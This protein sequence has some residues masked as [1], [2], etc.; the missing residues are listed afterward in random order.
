MGNRKSNTKIKSVT[1]TIPLHI[2]ETLQGL[3]DGCI[4]SA[5]DMAFVEEMNIVLDKLD[6]SINKVRYS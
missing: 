4:G 6:K 3:V 2:A 1:I 5:E